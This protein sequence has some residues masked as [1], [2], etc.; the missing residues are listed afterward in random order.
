MSS[1]SSYDELNIIP[2]NR[3]S[4]PYKEYFDKMS[5][6]YFQRKEENDGS[7]IKYSNR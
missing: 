3:R 7:C 4:E 6:T 2:S 5:I 1:I